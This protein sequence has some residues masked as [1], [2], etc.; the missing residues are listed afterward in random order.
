MTQFQFVGKSIPRVD[1]LDKVTGNL[2]YTS[3]VT[4][5]GMLH[6]KVLRSPHS[7]ARIRSIDVSA[8]VALAGVRAVITGEDSPEEKLGEYVKDRDVLARDVVRFRG[9]PVAA[10]AADTAEIAE[11]A[12]QLI[13]VEYEELPAVYDLEEAAS[14]EPAAVI[15][16]D[17]ADYVVMQ[18]PH[19]TIRFPDEMPN[20]YVH[21]PLRYGDVE[22]GFEEADVVTEGRYAVPRTQYAAMERRTVVVQPESDGG[23]TFWATTSRPV[24]DRTDIAR[25][26]NMSPSQVRLHAPPLGG[27]FGANNQSQVHM[28]L[29]GLLARK[30]RRPV[31]LS[32]TRAEDILD[33]GTRESTILY[34]KEGAKRDGTIVAREMK[35]FVDAGAYSSGN[36][37]LHCIIFMAQLLGVYRIANVKIDIFGVATNNPP[38]G[39][40][41]TF[42]S[43]QGYWAIEQSV[44]QLAEKLGLDAYEIR[45]RN[46]L[47]DGEENAGGAAAKS[48]A[49][50]RCLAKMAE[51]I[52]LDKP[53]ELDRGPWKVGKGL[54]LGSKHTASDAGPAVVSVKVHEDGT[55]EVRHSAA[56]HGMGVLTLL[57]QIAAEEF[58]TSVDR[59]RLVNIDTQV[60][61]FD[62]GTMGQ[63][64]T[65]N[66]GNALLMA[67][68]DVKTQMFTAAAQKLGVTPEELD[69]ADGRIFRKDDAE[70]GMAVGELFNVFGFYPAGGELLGRGIYFCPPKDKELKEDLAI[71]I[72]NYSTLYGYYCA[73]AEVAV[74][75]VTGEVKILRLGI[76]SDMGTPVNPRLID[77]QNY[78]GLFWGIGTAFLEEIKIEQGRVVNPDFYNWTM[79]TFVDM[80]ANENVASM[81][82]WARYEDGPL[83]AK[84]FAEGTMVPVAPALN[85]AIY[86][87]VGV[88]VTDTPVTKDKILADLKRVPE[89][90]DADEAEAA[91]LSAAARQLTEPITH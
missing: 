55:I 56:E 48:I 24:T 70:H 88:R 87:A 91:A 67:A 2:K 74:N 34:I 51:W 73:A 60:A 85:N 35:I 58:K 63:K 10:V 64:A 83:G 17:L 89:N 16:P 25:I 75:E 12:I 33:F 69:F 39:S 49:V 62:L 59:I 7:H 19:Q 42:G 8:A 36:L 72:A 37:V 66:N 44:D 71:G 45:Q 22:K 47:K 30:A 41:L 15:H 43:T 52:E 50:D 46:V 80:P 1:A 38:A 86:Q 9:E 76:C 61:G 14:R 32:L 26:L 65:T 21:R 23:L 6:A 81:T 31:R 77:V 40:F 11:Q 90:R 13:A 3:D 4:V 53:L 54:A 78:R 20:G 28:L 68:Q 57:T 27:H 84:G 82:A 79:P 5:P 18:Y 29:A